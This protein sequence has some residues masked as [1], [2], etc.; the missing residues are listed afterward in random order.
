MKI[1]CTWE[2]TKVG[3]TF[4]P[5]KMMGP[6]FCG[7]NLVR[8]GRYHAGL[9][10]AVRQIASTLKIT[11]NEPQTEGDFEYA[12]ALLDLQEWDDETLTDED[13][14]R[15]STK[16]QERQLSR[17]K[18]ARFL[19]GSWAT[20]ELRHNC[21]LGCCPRGPAQSCPLQTTHSCV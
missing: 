15:R 5:L 7:T 19:S 12:K 2:A 21:S 14:R 1:A 9:E 6:I 3:A 10:Q 4:T 20:G 17:L 13:L 8:R 18:L 11:L 16:K